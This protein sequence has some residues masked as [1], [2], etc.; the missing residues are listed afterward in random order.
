MSENPEALRLADV[1]DEG[2]NFYFE[3][4]MSWDRRLANAV[5]S[6]A[7]ELRRLHGVNAELLAALQYMV[8]EQ[9]REGFGDEM[10]DIKAARAAIAKATGEKA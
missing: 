4:S 3:S 1:L 8:R 5:G 9:E 10:P 6:A 2:E 7:E